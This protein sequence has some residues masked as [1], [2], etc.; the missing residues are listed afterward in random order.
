MIRFAVSTLQTDIQAI[1]NGTASTD[2]VNSYSSDILNYIAS[3]Q[4]IDAGEI[5]PAIIA[6]ADSASTQQETAV[7]VDVLQNDSYLTSSL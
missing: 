1:A 4:D 5:A 2:T 3:D 6:V 7:T